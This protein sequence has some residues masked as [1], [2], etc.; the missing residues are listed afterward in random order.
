[1]T[2]QWF[3]VCVYACRHQP[4][5]PPCHNPLPD[6]TGKD[7][8]IPGYNYSQSLRSAREDATFANASN[9]ASWHRLCSLER[10]LQA[11][12]LDP[13]FVGS[14]LYKP[15]SSNEGLMPGFSGF[16]PHIRSNGF[17]GHSYR[18]LTRDMGA[19]ARTD[20]SGIAYITEAR[21]AYQEAA[22]LDLE[23]QRTARGDGPEQEQESDDG[24]AGDYST[25]VQLGVKEMQ[26]AKVVWA[27][28]LSK[29]DEH[30][31]VASVAFRKLDHDHKGYIIPS[32]L[33]R[34]AKML[35]ISANEQELRVL[36]QALGCD[37]RGRVTVLDYMRASQLG[38]ADALKAGAC[39]PLLRDAM[40]TNQR[41]VRC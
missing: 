26:R 22:R 23:N 9:P 3:L 35:G 16:V 33:R 8:V 21:E 15:I 34:V 32:D 25:P 11:K 31:S 14:D 20:C 24:G 13:V 7:N 2:T 30:F 10:S 1:M 38:L 39:S 41:T 36:M 18:K 4:V 5:G 6:H 12:R 27:E 28:F 37:G 40:Q 19:L 17:P 29:M